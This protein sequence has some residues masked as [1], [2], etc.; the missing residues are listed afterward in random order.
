MTVTNTIAN[1]GNARR[2]ISAT[3][4]LPDR[5]RRRLG[6]QYVL[7]FASH[8]EPPLDGLVGWWTAGDLDASGKAI[9]LANTNN[10]T[11]VGGVQFPAGQKLASVSTSG[12]AGRL[13]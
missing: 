3:V 11:V 2:S 5:W 1:T 9:D 12:G 10:G 4:T 8:R 6:D 13:H 7:T